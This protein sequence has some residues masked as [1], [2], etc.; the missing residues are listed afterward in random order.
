MLQ[1]SLLGRGI[2]LCIIVHGFDDFGRDEPLK[3]HGF[4]GFDY[5]V[6]HD[7]SVDFCVKVVVVTLAD[8]SLEIPHWI[9][10]LKR[11]WVPPAE[12]AELKASDLL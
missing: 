9:T 3:E 5:H 1:P 6:I 11:Q 8:Y 10:H 2:F 12:L 4:L 7:F